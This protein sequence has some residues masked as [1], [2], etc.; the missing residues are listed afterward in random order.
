MAAKALLI[1]KKFELICKKDFATL[2]LDKNEQ[3]FMMHIVT[4]LVAFTIAIYSFQVAQIDLLLINKALVKVSFEYSN[5]TN[6]FALKTII[7]LIE[8]IGINDYAINLE[9]S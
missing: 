1:T 5:Y 8:Y 4:L 3:T 9:D 2:A 7:E 6:G